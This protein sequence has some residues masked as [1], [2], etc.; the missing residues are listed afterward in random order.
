MMNI[1]DGKYM[2]ATGLKI[3]H[4]ILIFFAL[5]SVYSIFINNL[6]SMKKDESIKQ[7]S[8]DPA[9]EELI[10]N[11]TKNNLTSKQI[12][13]QLIVER[14]EC[15]NNN[16]EGAQIKQHIATATNGN[17]HWGLILASGL[18]KPRRVNSIISRENKSIS[19]KK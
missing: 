2:L 19:F 12:V 8:Q 16:N 7:I 5:I 6:S 3:A 17:F 11:N 9:K 1:F 13:Q 15:P 4:I 18:S 10:E 14:C